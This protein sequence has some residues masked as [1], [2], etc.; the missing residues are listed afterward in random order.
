MDMRSGEAKGVLACQLLVGEKCATQCSCPPQSEHGCNSNST[1]LASLATAIWAS[2]GR[3]TAGAACLYGCRND[4]LGGP[5]GRRGDRVGG[6]YFLHRDDLA[7]LAPLWLEYTYRVRND[8]EVRPKDPCQ[9]TR[10]VGRVSA[11]RRLLL[12]C[13]LSQ[14]LGIPT[15][16]P[17]TITAGSCFA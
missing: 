4:T 10:F 5:A 6:P 3:L 9:H 7:K 8:S 15:P 17:S 13:P 2:A 11:C 1:N 12:G 14:Q 16:P